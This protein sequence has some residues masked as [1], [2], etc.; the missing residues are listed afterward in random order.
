[1]FYK[2]LEDPYRIYMLSSTRDKLSYARLTSSSVGYRMSQSSFNNYDLLQDTSIF[3]KMSAKEIILRH[4]QDVY[5]KLV[6]K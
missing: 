5:N 1:M 4:G 2:H 3:Q 6:Q